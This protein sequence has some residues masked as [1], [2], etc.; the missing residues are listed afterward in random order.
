MRAADAAAG[1]RCCRCRCR[2]A[3]L[4]PLL[5]LLLLL[6][7]THARWRLSSLPANETHTTHIY[8]HKPEPKSKKVDAIPLSR[9]KKN[10]ARDFA[11][12]VL[13]AEVVAAFFPKAVDLHNYSAASS[14]SQKLANWATLDRKVLRRLGLSLAREEQV[15]MQRCCV[16]C[17]W[18][19]GVGDVQ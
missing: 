17:V 5:L 10:I 16:L 13:A 12:G 1:R 18:G 19:G 2:C 15:C 8:I 6:L 3:P 9:P 7:H 14:M 11:D 4:P